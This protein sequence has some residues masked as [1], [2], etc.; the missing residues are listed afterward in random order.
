MH[1]SFHRHRAPRTDPLPFSPPSSWLNLSSTDTQVSSLLA[2]T[3][4]WTR[5][6]VSPLSSE[7]GDTAVH[8]VTPSPSGV[9]HRVR[10]TTLGPLPDETRVS[11]PRLFFLFPLRYLYV[12]RGHCTIHD[13]AYHKRIGSSVERFHSYFQEGFV[14]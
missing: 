11:L 5:R 12:T 10:P 8:T 2:T 6:S 7:S 1:E 4:N 3:P 13:P 14:L 9:L